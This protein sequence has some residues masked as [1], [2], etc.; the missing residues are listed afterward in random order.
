MTADAPF[1]PTSG[2][3]L[4]T[5]QNVCLAARRGPVSVLSIGTRDAEVDRL[6]GIDQWQHVVVPALAKRPPG[7]Y[8]MLLGDAANVAREAFERAFRTASPA[9]TVFSN[10]WIEGIGTSLRRGDAASIFDF[11]NVYSALARERH[12]VDTP[13]VRRLECETAAAVDA[14]WVC[15][16]A[17]ADHLRAACGAAVPVRV[18]PNGIDLDAYASVRAGR[19]R[20]AAA[21][22]A[23][24]LLFV[25]S[26]WYEPNRIAAREL[27]GDVL[28]RVRA[29]LGTTTRLLLVGAAPD[30][31]MLEAARGD[32]ALIV[33]GRVADVRPF[34]ALA[35]VVVVPLRHG[36]GTRLKILEAF[37]AGR[38]VVA[39]AK[40]I[41]GLEV[42]DGE[43]LLV[44]EDAPQIAA[45][46]CALV[47]DRDRGRALAE[48]AYELV[49]ERYGWDAV[50]PRVHA[51]L[52]SLHRSRTLD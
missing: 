15:S 51:A 22:S 30:A 43:H 39:T 28:P 11:H 36:G 7:G 37:A 21:T 8:P 32:R 14:C 33:T 13:D 19:S 24:A 46:V 38:P 50:A 44:R 42:R 49:R 35:D 1:P 16:D 40:A 27:I 25:G 6:P 4:R 20:R 31:P 2:T 12:D 29:E 10:L 34:L 45:A 48:R 5:W 26:F 3:P 17:D 9:L 52:I 18:I 47:R 41:E 23:A